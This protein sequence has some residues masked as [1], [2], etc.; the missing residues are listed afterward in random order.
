MKYCRHC[1]LMAM[2]LPSMTM[3]R[4][5]SDVSSERAIVDFLSSLSTTLWPMPSSPAVVSV[6]LN[7]SVWG[8]VQANPELVLHANCV[9]L[10]SVAGLASSRSYST[11]RTCRPTRGVLASVAVSVEYSQPQTRFKTFILQSTKTQNWIK[12]N[13]AVCRCQP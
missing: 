7:C 11:I 6:T 9:T 5:G 8:R 3:C 13:F 2:L 12:V 1:N 10:T 4:R